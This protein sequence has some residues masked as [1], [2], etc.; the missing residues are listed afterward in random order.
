VP[1]IPLGAPDLVVSS[2]D[3]LSV[4]R[5]AENCRVDR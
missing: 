2:M 1:V 4:V 3:T 5:E